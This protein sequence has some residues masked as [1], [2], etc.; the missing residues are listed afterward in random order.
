MKTITFT[1]DEYELLQAMVSLAMKNR[2]ALADEAD[3]EVVELKRVESFENKIYSRN[4]EHI[5]DVAINN[6]K[7]LAEGITICLEPQNCQNFMATIGKIF[8]KVELIKQQIEI[9]ERKQRG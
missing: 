2:D 3:L 8:A 7:E 5:T 1:D 6:I 9:W 4:A